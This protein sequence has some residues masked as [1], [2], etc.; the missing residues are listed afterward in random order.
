MKYFCP[1]CGP[2]MISPSQQIAGKLTLGAA[3]AIMGFKA[4]RDPVITLVSGLIGLW[5]GHEI[6]KRCPQCGAI[7]QAAQI[8]GLIG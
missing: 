4:S 2:L 8:F 7:V 5:V 6:D 1:N 3:G